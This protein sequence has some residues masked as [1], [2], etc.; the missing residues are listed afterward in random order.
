MT[1]KCFEG[2]END[3]NLSEPQEVPESRTIPS[4][5][6]AIEDLDLDLDLERR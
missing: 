1:N 2:L 4:K 6:Q 3:A 5:L